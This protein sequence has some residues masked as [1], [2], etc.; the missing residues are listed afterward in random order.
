VIEAIVTTY[1][2]TQARLPA[3]QL[4]ASLVGKPLAVSTELTPLVIQ[5]V[6]E[7][8][9]RRRVYVIALERKEEK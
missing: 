9:K 7:D 4:A 2:D 1:Q 6:R 3:L 5:A 8:E